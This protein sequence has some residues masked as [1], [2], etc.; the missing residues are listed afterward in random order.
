MTDNKFC[1]QLTFSFFHILNFLFSLEKRSEVCLKHGTVARD[2]AKKIFGDI[3]LHFLWAKMLGHLRHVY[4]QY[5]LGYL[6]TIP[7]PRPDSVCEKLP[8][9]CAGEQ[10]CEQVPDDALLR[11]QFLQA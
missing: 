3:Y 9:E 10:R 4:D 1:P 11:R 5:G 6:L 7:R 2:S 8:Q